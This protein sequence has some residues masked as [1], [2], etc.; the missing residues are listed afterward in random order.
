MSVKPLMNFDINSRKRKNGDSKDDGLLPVPSMTSSNQKKDIPSIFSVELPSMLGSNM[1]SVDGLLGDPMYQMQFRM[2][3]HSYSDMPYQSRMSDVIPKSILENTSYKTQFNPRKMLIELYSHF[4]KLGWFNTY[5]GC[6][7]IKAKNNV[8]FLSKKTIKDR[9]ELADIQ[10]VDLRDELKTAEEIINTEEV[11]K[12]TKKKEPCSQLHILPHDVRNAHAVIF[13]PTK[14]AVMV[15]I[16][17]PGK[18]FIIT[19]FEMIKGIRNE[20]TEKQFQWDDNLVIPIIE[21]DNDENVVLMAMREAMQDYPDVP[22]VLVRRRGLFVWGPYWDRAKA[23][24][25][26]LEYLFDIALQTLMSCMD[27]SIS[28]TNGDVDKK[29]SDVEVKLESRF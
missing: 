4:L 21:N 25:E 16:H 19:N 28:T 17:Y 14:N 18:E 20:T 9:I 2:P 29:S 26:V 27:P 10:V 24:A 11:P 1:G 8:F 12:K 23:H 15:T 6:I 22:A 7:T 3:E 5:A 13:L